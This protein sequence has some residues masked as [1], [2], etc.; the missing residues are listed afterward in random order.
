MTSVWSCKT[1]LSQDLQ[2]SKSCPSL[3]LLSKFSFK[4]LSGWEDGLCFG[5][6]FRFKFNRPPHRLLT[7]VASSS[8]AS[9]RPALSPALPP[10]NL[11]ADWLTYEASWITCSPRKNSF[12]WSLDSYR[13]CIH[14]SS[15]VLKKILNLLWF[16]KW[17]LALWA[18]RKSFSCPM[19]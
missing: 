2:L 15:K 5:A 13:L 18:E 7:S 1:T 10:A 4:R 9:S 16:I 8:S 12:L 11:V 14:R 17:F 19:P 3:C 6:S